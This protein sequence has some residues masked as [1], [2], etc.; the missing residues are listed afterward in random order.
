MWKRIKRFFTGP[1]YQEGY[2]W[3]SGYLLKEPEKAVTKLFQ[4]V[5]DAECVGMKPF[6]YG[7]LDA[8]HNFK[9]LW[10][11]AVLGGLTINN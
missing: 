3:A 1:T 2:E 10:N 8:L 11:L 4:L 5:Q 6:D 9:K 7:V